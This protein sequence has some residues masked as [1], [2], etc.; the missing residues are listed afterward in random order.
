MD[1]QK[2]ETLWAEARKRCRLSA[3]AIAM[4][5]ELG[6][7]PLSLIKN[8]PSKQELWKAPVEEWVRDMYAKRQEKAARRRE[9]NKKASAAAQVQGTGDTF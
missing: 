5:K 9:A 7:N 3:E 2:K 1:K 4:A 8:I 6:L